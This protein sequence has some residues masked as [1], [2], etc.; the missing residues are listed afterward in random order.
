VVAITGYT[1]K[2]VYV[3][4]ILAINVNWFVICDSCGIFFLQISSQGVAVILLTIWRLTATI[5]VVPHS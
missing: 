4:Y 2:R 1:A 3:E 5:W